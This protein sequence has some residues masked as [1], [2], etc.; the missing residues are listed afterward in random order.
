MPEIW[1]KIAQDNFKICPRYAQ[2]LPKVWG[3]KFR[4]WDKMSLGRVHKLGHYV[5]G[6]VHNAVGHFVVETKCIL[7]KQ[8]SHRHSATY[9]LHLSQLPQPAVVYFFQACALFAQPQRTLNFGLFWLF[10]E[11]LHT[12]WCTFTVLDNAVVFTQKLINITHLD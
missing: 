8:T 5:V 10:V 4:K 6:E 12:L 2:A 3:F 9:S 11:N 7:T 1:P